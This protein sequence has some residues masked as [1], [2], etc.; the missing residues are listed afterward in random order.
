M[1]INVEDVTVDTTKAEAQLEAIDRAIE[2]TARS[3]LTVSRKS[4]A[5]LS[6]LLGAFGAGIDASLN[7]LVNSAFLFAESFLLFAEAETILGSPRAILLFLTASVLFY[8]A[9]VLE[10]ERDEITKTLDAFTQVG[11]MW[12]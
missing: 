3:V 7:A 8:R 10:G 5:T 11:M 2:L 4:F 12:F 9:I 1:S 6:I